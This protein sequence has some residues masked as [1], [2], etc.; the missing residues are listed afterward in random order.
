MSEI[1]H[2]K[3]S[4]VTP[5][6][7]RMYK[8]G[9]GPNTFGYTSEDKLS[10][11]TPPIPGAVEYS[12]TRIIYHLNEDPFSQSPRPATSLEELELLYEEE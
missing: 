7:Q 8:V 5:Y 2:I 6:T 3:G 12:H 1:T 9:Y 4:K 11:I 10:T